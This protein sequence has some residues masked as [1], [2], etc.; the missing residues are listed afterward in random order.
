[1]KGSAGAAGRPAGHGP[2]AT[3]Q[4]PPRGKRTH[5][6]P[7]G[8]L[9]G[10]LGR[11]DGDGDTLRIATLKN[12]PI[13][14]MNP[15]SI[16]V[17]YAFDAAPGGTPYR[18]VVKLTG[19]LLDGTGEPSGAASF[20]V[21]ATHEE[22]LPGSGRVSLTHRID[23]VAP[24]RWTI[25]AE[26]FAWH[27]NAAGTGE[28]RRQLPKATA[29]G[30][31]MFTRA[32]RALAPGV[33]MGAWSSMV[34][35]GAVVALALQG[36]LALALGLPAGPI[37]LMSTG[38][39]VAGV[40]GAKIYYRLTHRTE[41]A[42]WLIGAMSL[43]GFVIAIAVILPLVA[44]L[45]GVSPTVLLDL[46]LAPLLVGQAIG[47]LGCVLGGC[48]VGRPTT[49]RWG[50]WSSDRRVGTRRI[51]VQLMESAM[52][53]VVAVLSALLLLLAPPQV[54]GTVFV[55]GFGAYVLGRQLLF[56]LRAQ[57]RATRH[58]RVLTLVGAAAALV[59]AGALAV[60]AP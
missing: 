56:P 47:R 10:R 27:R 14:E 13:R 12:G 23:D 35:L 22:V 51:P 58:G 46:T 20:S 19:R 48:C 17:S 36:V 29:T 6:P 2:A 55:G 39:A 37:A 49:S 40:A 24:G 34:G 30:A 52:A 21:S 60:A 57:P 16:A 31:T 38:A 1:M 26:A 59:L 50:G 9:L 54:P 44:P 53:A 33:L 18:V 41:P 11:G 8:P 28:V 42:S 5:E 4:R 32:A 3:D 15:Q 25:S 43:Q 7:R 45:A